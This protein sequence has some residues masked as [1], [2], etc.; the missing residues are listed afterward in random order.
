MTED[1]RSRLRAILTKAADCEASRQRALQNGDHARVAA[2]EAELRRLG[3]EHSD[4]ER[5]V[6]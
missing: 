4:L 5:Q 6:A 1:I 3:A 2:L